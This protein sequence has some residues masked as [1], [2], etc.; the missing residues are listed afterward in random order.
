MREIA[1][2]DAAGIL[3]KAEEQAESMI[4]ETSIIEGANK[5]SEEMINEAQ[6]QSE[7]IV[8]NAQQESSRML[9]ESEQVSADRRD[10][11]DNYAKEVLYALE[12]RI[13]TILSQVRSGLD[14]LDDPAENENITLEQNQ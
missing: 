11:A 1:K 6:S 2:R 9:E 10:G 4:E 14:L 5:K 7:G 8:L 3:A 13:S 12:E